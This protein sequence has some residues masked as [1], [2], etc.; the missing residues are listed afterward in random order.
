MINLKRNALQG[1]VRLGNRRKSNTVALDC[2]IAIKAVM[3][4]RNAGRRTIREKNHGRK[5]KAAVKSAQANLGKG[6]K[7]KINH[8][9]KK[10]T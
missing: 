2:D 5:E 3:K 7:E 10:K 4:R 1:E 6:Q 8:G 9:A